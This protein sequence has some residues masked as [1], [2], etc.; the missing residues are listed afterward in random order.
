MPPVRL[1]IGIIFLATLLG[2][3]VSGAP[4]AVFAGG[5]SLS[6]IILLLWRSGDLPIFLI[7]ILNQ[8]TQVAVK[9][10]LTIFTGQPIERTLDMGFHQAIGYGNE[11]AALFG[12][13]GITCLAFGLWFGSGQPRVQAE[14]LLRTE[15]RGWNGGLL[16]RLAVGAIVAG[17]FMAVL[18]S[19]A[20]PAYQLVLALSGLESIGIFAF[21]YWC[22]VNG[23]G[24]PYLIAIMT[25]EILSGI[26]GFFAD[27]RLPIMVL[28]VAALT[29]RPSLRLSTLLIVAVIVALTVALAS[30]WSEIKND[31]RVYASEGLGGQN[32][33]QSFE[34]RLGYIYDAAAKF[35]GAQFADGFNKLL[36]RQS[37]ID[38][39]GATM[40]YVPE[41]VSHEDGRLVGNAIMNM[42]MPRILFPDKPPLPDDTQVTS[43]YTGIR[44][45]SAG[46]TSISIGY[47]GE[48]YIDFGY[49]GAL[50]GM[51]LLG[52][53]F[54]FGYRILRDHEGPPLLINYGICALPA[55]SLL[56]FETA[57]I[58]SM[59]GWVLAF[60]AA[61]FIQR[62]LAPRVLDQFIH[63]N[64]PQPAQARFTQRR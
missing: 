44:F 32:V 34:G 51:A 33:S 61:L 45:Y 64:R 48:L 5:A 39:L 14:F 12:F 20:G 55:L 63:R 22:F 28:A 56:N 3:A 54:G 59:N 58:K 57:L 40:N 49:Y 4:I 52:I 27:F 38:F 62:F 25:F 9:P 41:M 21:A 2:A 6:A 53:V 24:Y 1:A 42:L 15:A 30:F 11:Q 36:D 50:L 23:K 47:L 60:G 18:A 35:D 43:M 37:Y 26:T 16:L 8:W 46:D 29:A 7:P 31:Y 19:Y 10:I 17:R 13:A